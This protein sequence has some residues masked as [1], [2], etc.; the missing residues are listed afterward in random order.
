MTP[1]RWCPT[2]ILSRPS[3]G[4]IV[5]GRQASCRILGSW[6][7]FHCMWD[8]S[9][10]SQGWQLSEL[11]TMPLLKCTPYLML[12]E[13]FPSSSFNWIYFLWACMP[14]SWPFENSL[15]IV[16]K[17]RFKKIEGWDEKQVREREREMCRNMDHSQ[18]THYKYAMGTKLD[19]RF[20]LYSR[21]IILDEM[22]MKSGGL[23]WKCVSALLLNH[24]FC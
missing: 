23:V 19:S 22:K 1:H 5:R 15:S 3:S 16:H 13:I 11:A 8:L 10:T 12:T 9:P 24:W 21:L 7:Q 14:S 17:L 20:R 4:T 18:F 2:T 6:I